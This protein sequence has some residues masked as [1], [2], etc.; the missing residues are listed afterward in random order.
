MI[1]G[2]AS[3][4]RRQRGFTLL[5]LMIGMVIGL[6]IILAAVTIFDSFTRSS[7]YQ[8]A[9]SSQVDAGRFALAMIGREARMAGFRDEAWLNPP[10]T[11]ALAV[12]NGVAAPDAITV[13]YEGEADCLGTPTIAPDF[14]VTNR[15]DVVDGN[16]RCNGEVLI[17][18]VEDLQVLLG[19]DMT[20]DRTPNRILA[21]GTVGLDPERIVTIRV[22]LLLVTLEDRIRRT[23]QLLTFY[24]A[25]DGVGEQRVYD[26][27]RHRIE[28][29][30]VLTLRNPR[31]T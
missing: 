7:R 13:R 20:G 24:G 26:D 23:P 14:I 21:P 22:H 10:L 12:E 31:I 1:S 16:L 9:I 11:N 27:G 18:G 6:V 25:L 2:N 29:S 5:E 28:V 30:T 17:N 4:P 3:I 19:E 15:F 8:Q